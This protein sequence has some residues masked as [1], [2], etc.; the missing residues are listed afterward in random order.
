MPFADEVYVGE[1]RGRPKQTTEERLLKKRIKEENGGKVKNPNYLVKKAD[2]EE[3]KIKLREV[4]ENNIVLQ[5]I[6]TEYEGEDDTETPEIRKRIVDAS[7]Y[8]AG[9]TK[10]VF[11]RE[12]SRM[13]LEGKPIEA[14]A[15]DLKISTRSVYEHRKKLQ[16]IWAEEIRLIDPAPIYGKTIHTLDYIQK[17]AISIAH[18]TS[19]KPGER[20]KALTEARQVEDTKTRFF[21]E[22]GMFQGNP[23]RGNEN[24]D[25]LSKAH[26]S[27]NVL[28]E[29]L[30]IT[31]GIAMEG[32]HEAGNKRP[33][34]MT[35]EINDLALS[36]GKDP[37]QLIID[38]NG[39]YIGVDEDDED[40]DGGDE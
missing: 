30:K 6:Q 27:A 19:L 10:E 32:A 37:D 18:D 25:N 36:L 5:D 8:F 14:I 34:G 40:M 20:I 29:R 21:K 39:N 9:H 7:K 13:L 4:E 15:R 23:I 11:Y 22:A 16:Q 3:D 35:L 1:K 33:S 2:S 28:K 12:L 38:E 31:M 17:M 24:S 26:K